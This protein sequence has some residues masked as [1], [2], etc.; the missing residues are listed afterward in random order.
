MFVFVAAEHDF[1][2]CICPWFCGGCAPLAYIGADGVCA[3]VGGCVQACAY[4][5]W[6]VEEYADFV[7][8]LFGVDCTV[9]EC[10]LPVSAGDSCGFESACEGGEVVLY[11]L[12][13]V[14]E[15]G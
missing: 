12:S 4:L 7:G 2:S 15:V 8:G 9:G 1:H 5:V 3:G 14:S 13:F 10:S 6:W 11:A